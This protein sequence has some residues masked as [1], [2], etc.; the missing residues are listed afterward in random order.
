M[1]ERETKIVEEKRGKEIKNQIKRKK[2]GERI[3]Q[4]LRRTTTLNNNNNNNNNNTKIN[5]QTN[6]QIETISATASEASSYE[7][8]T[9]TSATDIEVM[10]KLPSFFIIQTEWFIFE[11]LLLEKKTITNKQNTNKQNTNK[12]NINKQNINKQTTTTRIEKKKHNELQITIPKNTNERVDD[13][14]EEEEEK[15]E[16]KNY[17]MWIETTQIGYIQNEKETINSELR[18]GMNIENALKDI[19]QESTFKTK[20]NMN[21]KGKG[22]I[23]MSFNI[24]TIEDIDELWFNEEGTRFYDYVEKKINKNKA[25]IKMT[26]RLSKYSSHQKPLQLKMVFNS[27]H[28]RN[29]FYTHNRLISQEIPELEREGYRYASQLIVSPSFS[30]DGKQEREHLFIIDASV[31][32]EGE[33]IKATKLAIK[34]ILKTIPRHKNWFNIAAFGGGEA[35]TCFEESMKITKKHVRE[36]TTFMDKLDCDQIRNEKLL[37]PGLKALF[38]S[39]AFPNTPRYAYL[40]TSGDIDDQTEATRYINYHSESTHVFGLIIGDRPDK[41]LGRDIKWA[42]HGHCEYINEA[43]QINTTLQSLVDRGTAAAY[44]NVKIE[45][46]SKTNKDDATKKNMKVLQTPTVMP[47][48]MSNNCYIIYT[49]STHPINEALITYTGT[50]AESQQLLTKKKE[51]DIPNYV[52]Q[53][54]AVRLLYEFEHGY[55]QELHGENRSSNYCID[56]CKQ[57][58]MESSY[59]SLKF[60]SLGVLYPLVAALQVSMSQFKFKNEKTIESPTATISSSSPNSTITSTTSVDFG[61]TFAKKSI[62]KKKSRHTTTFDPTTSLSIKDSLKRNRSK[63]KTSSRRKKQPTP[64]VIISKNSNI[65]KE[66]LACLNKITPLRYFEVRQDFVKI[67]A[68]IQ[69]EDDVDK[70]LVDVIFDFAQVD[71]QHSETYARLCFDTVNDGHRF[72]FARHFRRSLKEKVE[73]LVQK[74]LLATDIEKIPNINTE[75]FENYQLSKQRKHALAQFVVELVNQGVRSY[76]YLRSCCERLIVE[77]ETPQTIHI[78]ICGILLKRCTLQYGDI[79]VFILRLE[80]LQSNPE[81]SSR[82][83]FLLMDLVDE[84]KKQTP[85]SPKKSSPTLRPTEVT[86]TRSRSNSK[87]SSLHVNNRT[88]D[89]SSITSSPSHAST[90][91]VKSIPRSRSSL[92]LDDMSNDTKTDSIFIL[93]P[94]PTNNSPINEIK[95]NSHLMYVPPE[96][97]FTTPNTSSRLRMSEDNGFLAAIQAA[98]QQR[99]FKKLDKDAYR[100][101]V[102][103][104]LE[105]CCENPKEFDEVL[106]ECNELYC[107]PSYEAF[108]YLLVQCALEVG[109]QEKVRIKLMVKFIQ[110]LKRQIQPS[111][112]KE[113]FVSYLGNIHSTSLYLDMPLVFHWCGL[114]ISRVFSLNVVQDTLLTLLNSPDTQDMFNSIPLKQIAYFTEGLLLGIKDYAG[115]K[116]ESI[117]LY[118]IKQERFSPLQFIPEVVWRNKLKKR[119]NS[120]VGQRLRALDLQ[121]TPKE[122][123][124]NKLRENYFEVIQHTDYDLQLKICQFI[125]DEEPE[126]HIL[127]WLETISHTQESIRKRLFSGFVAGLLIMSNCKVD[128]IKEHYATVLKKLINPQTDSKSIASEIMWLTDRFRKSPGM[129]SNQLLQVLK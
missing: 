125:L 53:V 87:L 38:S 12:Q 113:G 58:H 1:K 92:K 91:T 106:V 31:A 52:H 126:H 96:K 115:Q 71:Q 51:S 57:F 17:E 56:L 18:Y 114:I 60:S 95:L 59:A 26:T 43:D 80:A 99:S 64:P 66:V 89:D 86:I 83:T 47:L 23:D 88:N 75:A 67:I 22:K 121:Y 78:E 30:S 9:Y 100:S 3:G 117:M 111:A 122:R 13:E 28:K 8:S 128:Y 46:R 120:L 21:I 24:Q 73:H 81:Y 14:E 35:K 112:I 55:V 85:T 97:G 77:K 109:R 116:E 107:L 41:Q 104:S 15:E 72:K 36:A 79:E 45:W 62:S 63:K 27:T 48:I 34:K 93:P 127:S 37:V 90:L 84:L 39:K 105:S 20:K 110:Y 102:L 74:V 108:H 54:A 76:A 11:Q 4:Q 6:K 50:N 44:T 68:Q 101:G 42:C 82:T 94:S 25:T 61:I 5:K 33:R 119:T 98:Q 29:H 70:Y 40:I 10:R 69:H 103:N 118:I 32:F 129:L 49:F 2:H 16:E 124:I 123:L 19:E 7:G 65:R